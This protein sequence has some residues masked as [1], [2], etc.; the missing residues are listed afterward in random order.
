MTH[1]VTVDEA[2][3]R[4]KAGALVVDVREK[5]EVEVAPLPGALHIPLGDLEERAHEIPVDRDV[6]LLCHH[7]VRSAYATRFLREAG[8]D[9]AFN[10]RGGIE[11]WARDVD[12]T[13]ARY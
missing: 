6:L 1:V 5:W 3:R 10:V 4:Q 11:A 13:L 2:A 8:W 12:A 9:R 7:G